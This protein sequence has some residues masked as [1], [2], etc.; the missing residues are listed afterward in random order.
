MKQGIIVET[1]IWFGRPYA[2]VLYWI[3]TCTYIY[4]VSILFLEK[5]SRPFCVTIDQQVD[6][7]IRGIKGMSKRFLNLP[8]QHTHNMQ[9]STVSPPPPPPPCPSP[10]HSENLAVSLPPRGTGVEIHT[11][12][13]G[14]HDHCM[15]ILVFSL[16]KYGELWLWLCQHKNKET[17][18]QLINKGLRIDRCFHEQNIHL[19]K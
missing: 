1:F 19:K 13:R 15:H 2:N 7:D 16:V 3:H 9:S 6:V 12:I 17:V 11:R 5:P 4:T 18:Q 14:A 8:T 10:W